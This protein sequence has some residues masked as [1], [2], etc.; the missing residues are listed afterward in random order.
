LPAKVRGE[1]RSTASRIAAIEIATGAKITEVRDAGGNGGSAA[2]TGAL[3]APDGDSQSISF[4]LAKK[5]SATTTHASRIVVGLNG[6]CIVP[7]D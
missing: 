3:T 2:S 7:P 5:E 4:K 1:A 6:N